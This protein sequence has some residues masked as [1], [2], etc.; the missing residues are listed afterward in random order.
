MDGLELLEDRF[1]ELAH[2]GCVPVRRI[3]G[4]LLE[5]TVGDLAY[6]YGIARHRQDLIQ[7]AEVPSARSIVS[8]RSVSTEASCSRCESRCA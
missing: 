5:S 3:G 1:V 6:L 2:K 4:D 8:P 7:I